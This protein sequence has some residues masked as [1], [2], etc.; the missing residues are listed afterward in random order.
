MA[1]L[2]DNNVKLGPAGALTELRN[3]YTLMFYLLLKAKASVC[4]SVTQKFCKIVF[5]CPYVPTVG[6]ESKNFFDF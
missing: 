3:N 4:V 2:I 6:K 5:M 1:R